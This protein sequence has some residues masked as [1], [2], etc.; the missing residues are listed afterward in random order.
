MLHMVSQTLV[1]SFCKEDKYVKKANLIFKEIL[2]KWKHTYSH[3]R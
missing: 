1:R 3:K 2:V